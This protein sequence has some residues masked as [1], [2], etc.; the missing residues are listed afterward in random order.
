MH[1]GGSGIGLKGPHSYKSY[2]K[3]LLDESFPGDEVGLVEFLDSWCGLSMLD[4]CLC[5]A[6]FSAVHFLFSVLYLCDVFAVGLEDYCH[7]T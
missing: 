5:G 6:D 3:A 4:K 1:G 2:C 7:F